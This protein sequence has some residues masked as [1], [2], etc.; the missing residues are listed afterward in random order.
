MSLHLCE[1]SR[2]GKFI[3]T[4]SRLE[5]AGRTGGWGVTANEREISF[6]VMKIYW[7]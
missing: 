5:V 2:I 6:G 7:N 1:K 3:D 4:E